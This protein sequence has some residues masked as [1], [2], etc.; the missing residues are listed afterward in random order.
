MFGE[1]DR[2]FFDSET[3]HVAADGLH[4]LRI[5]ADGIVGVDVENVEIFAC[6]VPHDRVSVRDVVRPGV[7]A[8]RHRQLR[9]GRFESQISGL[10]RG[11]VIPGALGGEAGT[12]LLVPE[13]PGDHFSPEG[14]RGLFRKIVGCQQIGGKHRVFTVLRPCRR[15]VVHAENSD[16]ARRKQFGISHILFPVEYAGGGFRLLPVHAFPND[17]QPGAAGEL[18]DGFIGVG[19]QP[20][21]VRERAGQPALGRI[22]RKI[23]PGIRRAAAGV[24]NHGE[25]ADSGKTGQFQRVIAVRKRVERKFGV[26]PLPLPD[27]LV[28]PVFQGPARRPRGERIKPEFQGFP[29][30]ERRAGGSGVNGQRSVGDSGRAP[31]CRKTPDC[32]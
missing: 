1:P 13:L 11:G 12:V 6:A 14:L 32:G 16:A 15:I 27:R 2:Q 4:E 8:D 3:L 24:R 29:L 30:Q 5:I 9:G 19:H 10:Q 18:R 22:H 21:I 7:T 26:G 28:L 25:R 23:E 17:P 20:R 31:G